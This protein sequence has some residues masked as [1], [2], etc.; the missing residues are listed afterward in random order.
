MVDVDHT[1]DKN[2]FSR[3]GRSGG[4]RRRRKEH[5]IELNEEFW[6]GIPKTPVLPSFLWSLI[7]SLLSV[8]NPLLTG[9]ADNIQSQNLYAGWAMH[10]G[11]Q[12]YGDFFGTN[13][14]LYYLLVFLSYLLKFPVVIAGFQFIALFIAG[15]YL[16]KIV[17]YFAKQRAVADQITIWFYLFIMAIG[18]GGIH[19]SLFALPFLLTSIWFLIR[20]FENAARDEAFI[21]YGIDAALVFMIYPKSILLWVVASLVLFVYNTQQKR[22]ARGIYQFL[23]SVFGFLLITYT[24]G[25]YAFE[26]QILG[27]AIQQT[28]LY[29]LSLEFT[30]A[31]ILW[32]LGTVFLFLVLSGFLVNLFR[33]MASLKA[34]SSR[35]IKIVVLLAFLVQLVFVIGNASFDLH[36]LIILLP[37][38][39]LMAVLPLQIDGNTEAEDGFDEFE[40]L[41][42]D[43]SYLKT[44]WFL[45]LVICLAIPFIPILSYLQEGELHQERL[46]VAHYIQSNS[47]QEDQLVAWDNSAQLYL[48]SK[49]LSAVKMLATEPYLTNEENQT[50][51]V[52]DINKNKAKFVVVNKDLALL[53]SVEINLD[54]HY[55]ELDLGTTHL[56]VYQLNE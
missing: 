23:A 30:D 35:Y 8:A 21:L 47:Q 12:P 13:G 20:Y 49:R 9:L 36:Q 46:T 15:I 18:F 16:N 55:T 51:M 33:T 45:P 43:Y 54:H 27:M 44:S 1:I 2:D 22:L 7:V 52:Y 19:A 5:E 24:V 28:F 40:E 29:T 41:K 56:Q 4:R 17:V 25:Y 48:Q 53:E 3:K 37:Y 34:Q 39:F 6:Q 32:T 38:G 42:P 31:S 14:V 10:A 50:S 11:Q 26:Q